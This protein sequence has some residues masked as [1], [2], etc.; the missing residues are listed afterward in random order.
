MEQTQRYCK[1]EVSGVEVTINRVTENRYEA[2]ATVPTSILRCNTIKLT[3]KKFTIEITLKVPPEELVGDSITIRISRGYVRGH[4]GLI[5]MRRAELKFKQPQLSGTLILD[6]KFYIPPEERYNKKNLKAR[7]KEKK[8]KKQ[9]EE[10][11]KPTVPLLSTLKSTNITNP[12]SG[13]LK[14][15]K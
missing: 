10:E 9:L 2:I 1:D 11:S 6:P 8:L 12:F 14:L 7:S 5:K 3:N 15:T 13:G 4:L